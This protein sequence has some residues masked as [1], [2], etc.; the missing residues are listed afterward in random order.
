MLALYSESLLSEAGNSQ[1][2]R[3]EAANVIAAEVQRLSSLIG[4]MLSMSQIENG[5]LSPEKSLV[6]LNDVAT[7]GVR[8][9]ESFCYRPEFR[10]S[11]LM[12]RRK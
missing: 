4:G 6:K 5:S 3:I 9:S 8:G 10:V 11:K 12:F 7:S 1:E 2:F